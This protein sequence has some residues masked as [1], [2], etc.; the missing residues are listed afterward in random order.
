VRAATQ[1]RDFDMT[2][3]G[4]AVL[5]AIALGSLGSASAEAQTRTTPQMQAQAGPDEA[6]SPES[7]ARR[8][9]PR[10]QVNPGRLLYRQC[11]LRYVLED[12]P[13]G[14]VLVPH[15]HCWWVRG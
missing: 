10:I 13:S 7:T 6:A 1:R 3:K 14:T 9:R 2:V 8:A 15:Q 5:A 12:R 11:S 4:F